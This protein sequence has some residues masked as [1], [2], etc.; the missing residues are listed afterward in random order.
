MW[1]GNDECLSIPNFDCCVQFIRPGHRAAGVAIYRR[2]NNS[3]V[4]TL[5]MDI[6]YPETS[7]LGIASQDNGDIV[8][9]AEYVLENGQTVISVTVYISLNQMVKKIADFLHFVLLPYTEDGSALLKTNYHS[10]PM[11]LSGYFNL[12]FSLPEAEPLIA[13]L[14]DQLMFE[15]NTDRN[16]STTNSG[17]VIDAVFSTV[18]KNLKSQ[19]IKTGLRKTASK[20]THTER[21]LENGSRGMEQNLDGSAKKVYLSYSYCQESWLSGRR[22]VPQKMG[23]TLNS[24]IYCQQLDRLKLAIDWKRPELANRRDVVFHQDNARSHMSVVT[25][26]NLWELSSEVLIHPPYS[27][28][29]APNDYHLFL[30]LQNFLSDKKLG[31]RE[32]WENRL[33]EFFVNKIQDFYERGIMKLP[34]KRQQIIQ[35]ILDPNRTIQNML[36]K[37]MNFMQ[38]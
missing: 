6:I 28:N 17:S 29:L 2:Q 11:I 37:V 8:C 25:H 1:L 22:K 38:K 23:Q 27:P 21:T 31:S 34:L 13:F 15:M 14:T 18:F 16:I 3:H 24:D 35:Q 36:N 7:G 5:H 4:A 32:D 9:A 30:A 20:N 12:N 33:L 19:L 10:L 26:Q